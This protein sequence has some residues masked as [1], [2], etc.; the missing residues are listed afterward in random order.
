MNIT[1][2]LQYNEEDLVRRAQDYD[3]AAFGEIYERYFNGVYKYTY[4]RVG[5]Q[6]VAEDIAMDVFAKAM[7]SIDGFAFRGVPFSAW[8]YRIASN[9]VVDHFRRQ[10]SQPALSL[11]E[12]LVADVAHPTQLLDQEFSH[13]ALR[14]ALAEL[15]DDQQQVVILKFVDG[16]SNLE[17][18]QI[19]G[20]T[21]GAIKSLQHRALA[22]LGRVL[23]DGG[24]VPA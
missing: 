10:P 11:E 21:E 22:S 4:Y 19:L 16:L 23:G 3:P 7:E 12:K 5:D 15:T 17:V 9:M 8:L 14:Q 20:K 24:E 6:V 13:Q 18:A 1:E 2:P